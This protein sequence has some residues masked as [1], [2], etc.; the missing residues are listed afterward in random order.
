MPPSLD[1]YFSFRSPYSYLAIVRLRAII[2]E[3]GIAARLK[4]VRPLAMR[5]PDFFARSRPQFLP[6]LLRD[7][8]REAARL[9]MAF[10]M[11]RPD[12]IDMNLDT[13]VVAK[14]QPLM[15]RVMALGIAASA[16]GHGL[17]FALAVSGRIWGGVENWNRDDCLAQA[18]EEAGLTLVA[19]EAWGQSHGDEI[20]NTI[21]ANEAA[22]IEHHWGVPLMVLDGEPFFG[23]DRLDALLWRLESKGLHKNKTLNPDFIVEEHL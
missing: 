21:R 9:D 8:V 23:Q 5:E 2:A 19:L 12:P 3:H 4:I 18:A 7:V 14:E 6:Y 22:Q 15:K 1:F 13:G 20:E 10:A 17:A 11:P 16:A